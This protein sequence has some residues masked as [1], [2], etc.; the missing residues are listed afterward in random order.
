MC[1]GIFMERS[2]NKTKKESKFQLKSNDNHNEMIK[3][4]GELGICPEPKSPKEPEL[5]KEME[6]TSG[7]K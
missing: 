5:L 1:G 3:V 2:D 4:L 6:I 7:I